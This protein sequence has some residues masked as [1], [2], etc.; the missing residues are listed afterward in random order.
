MHDASLPGHGVAA[1]DG[2]TRRHQPVVSLGL[3]HHIG[4]IAAVVS[5]ILDKTPSGVIVV[6]VVDAPAGSAILKVHGVG[7]GGDGAGVLHGCG[8]IVA[9]RGDGLDHPRGVV[10]THFVKVIPGGVV[11]GNPVAVLVDDAV[12]GAGRI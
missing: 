3:I 9:G 2:D 10:D 6:V 5:I 1:G 7:E 8:R 4:T 12:A 11:E